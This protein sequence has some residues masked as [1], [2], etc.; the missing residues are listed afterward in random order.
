[1]PHVRSGA[2]LYPLDGRTQAFAQ[3]GQATEC[4]EKGPL[5]RTLAELHQRNKYRLATN[6]SRGKREYTQVDQIVARS[7]P[8][9]LVDLAATRDR[10]VYYMN[11]PHRIP[12]PNPKSA[13]EDFIDL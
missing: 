5:L 4:S 7:A 6:V 9:T 11:A 3:V 12:A 8:E 13:W 1:M 10:T 2:S